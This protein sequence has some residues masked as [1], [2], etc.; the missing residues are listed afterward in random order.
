MPKQSKNNKSAQ[1]ANPR[2][3][4]CYFWLS[5]KV[6]S[7]YPL[8]SNL[9]SKV[10]LIRFCVI[11]FIYCLKSLGL[12]CHALPKASLAMTISSVDLHK[13]NSC[14]LDTSLHCVP[15]SMTNDCHKKKK[16]VILNES[17]LHLVI[18]SL[19]KRRSIHFGDFRITCD[20][21]TLGESIYLVFKRFATLH[22]TFKGIQMQT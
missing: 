12:Y 1:S 7:P 2:K 4:F 15:L 20:S 16:P 17:N 8:D 5:P 3:S 21:L 11:D 10:T 22:T 19:C 6:E 18:L 9:Q 14:G 13:F